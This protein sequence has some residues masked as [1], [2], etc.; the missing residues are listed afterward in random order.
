[1]TPG[2]YQ[3]LARAEARR[4]RPIYDGGFVPHK[5]NFV[6]RIG[7][8]IIY[9]A[10]RA[11]E[12]TLRYR[13]EDRAGNFEK[14]SGHQFIYCVWHNRLALCMKV[15][16]G[17][18]RIRPPVHGLAALIS[19]SRD[20]GFLTSTLENF[21]VQPVRGSTSRR[22]QQALLEL[23][24]WAKRGY[25]IGITPYGPRGPRCAVQ[26]GIIALAQLTG[27]PVVAAGYRL[28]WKIRVKSWDQFQIPLPFSRCEVVYAR[29]M[30]VPRDATPEERE[31]L[32]LQLEQT[33]KEI[34]RD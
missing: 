27:L 11:V 7:A 12:M 13:W 26:E 10:I 34:S 23:T 25:D 14:S 15:Y 21:G 24:R 28:N 16:F 18:A 30:I 19:A 17:Y 32:R 5:S 8:R 1:M 33:L 22:G 20:G 9:A 4:D 31:K 3:R 29:P 6:Q 2:K